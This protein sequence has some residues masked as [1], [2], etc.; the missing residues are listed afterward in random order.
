MK[1]LVVFTVIASLCHAPAAFAAESLLQTATRVAQEM[2]RSGEAVVTIAPRG[3]APALAAPS[4][5]PAAAATQAGPGLAESGLGKGR[6]ILIGLAVAVAFAGIAY[7]IDHSV[8]DNTPSS[9][10]ERLD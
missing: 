1:Q 10:G 8:E 2:A 3:V 7:K 6:K 4:E 5:R 9:R